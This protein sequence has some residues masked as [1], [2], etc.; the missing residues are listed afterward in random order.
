MRW[1]TLAT[2]IT[3]VNTW[4]SEVGYCR[5]GLASKISPIDGKKSSYRKTLYNLQRSKRKK[6]WL[7]TV[8]KKRGFFVL[9]TESFLQPRTARSKHL[10]T[11]FL[12]FVFC[13]SSTIRL[14]QD[15]GARHRKLNR[16]SPNL[17][18]A[19]SNTTFVVELSICGYSRGYLLRYPKNYGYSCVE[20]SVQQ[21][22]TT[23]NFKLRYP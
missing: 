22:I 10:R 23:A 7:K 3:W 8:G 9:I 15:S 16:I 11:Y 2:R 18:V 19:K 5:G 6:N 14:E 4:S 21:R 12:P 20:L 17:T 1:S 13:S